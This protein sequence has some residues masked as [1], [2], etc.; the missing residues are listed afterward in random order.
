MKLANF[1]LGGLLFSSPAVAAQQNGPQSAPLSP[2][3]Q[4]LVSADENDFSKLEALAIR[5]NGSLSPKELISKISNC[6][7]RRVYKSGNS[8][9]VLA[10]WMCAEG[11]TKSRVLIGSVRAV[12]DRVA[13]DLGRETR[14]NIPAPPRNGSALSDAPQ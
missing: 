4:F 2:V 11:N 3:A 14:N 6:Y 10:A 9:E 13:V 7:L 12:N 1:I 5:D 8:G